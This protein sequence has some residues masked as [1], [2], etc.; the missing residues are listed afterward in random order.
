MPTLYPAA[1][2]PLNALAKVACSYV[3]ILLVG[4]SGTGK[5]L[6]AN[7]T[8]TLSQRRGSFVAVNCGGLAATLVESLLFG[9]VKGAF[10]GAGTDALGLI[11]AAHHGTLFL[12]EIGCLPLGAQATL[13]RVLQEHEVIPVGATRPIFVDFRVVCAT[14]Q[15]LDNL[16]DNGRF[17]MD[18]L[19]RIDGFRHTLVPLRARKAD[20]GIII[21]ALLNRLAPE[22]LSTVRFSA[23]AMR[24]LVA[25]DWPG[26]IRELEQALAR[27]LAQSADGLIRSEDLGLR[28]HSEI[29]SLTPEPQLS[30]ETSDPHLREELISL[31]ATHNGSVSQVARSMGKARMQIQRWMRRFEIDPNEFR[32]AK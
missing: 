16:V 5:E 7:R 13:L 11:R 8:H 32:Q 21:A 14:N 2:M 19:N 3:P 6:L 29:R 26:N 31:L 28:L 30:G 27:A 22:R 1:V 15:S 20:I 10:S 9:H 17:R 12:D 23:N 25:Y 18:L 24:K 4:E